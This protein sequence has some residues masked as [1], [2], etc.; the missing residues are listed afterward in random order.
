MEEFDLTIIGGG[1]GG[2]VAASGDVTGMFPF[3]HMAEYEQE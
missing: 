1:V 3:T 2:L